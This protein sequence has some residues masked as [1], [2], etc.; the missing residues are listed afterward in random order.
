MRLNICGWLSVGLIYCSLVAH[1]QQKEWKESY[2]PDGKLRYKGY[3]IGKQPVG[4]VV[5]YYPSGQMKARLNYDGEETKA[6]IY[7]K[8]GE[9]TSSGKYLNREKTGVWEYRKG[10]RLLTREEYSK[11][12]LDG[13]SF[14]YYANGKIAEKK[15]WK[16]GVLSGE[17]QVFYDNG[18]LKFAT[19]FVAGKLQGPLTAYS[20]EGKKSV[21]GEYLNNVKEG[22]WR[23]YD[24]EGK[25]IRERAYK[26]G[27]S[28]R[29]QEDDLLENEQ[30][31]QLEDN[32][33][34]IVDPANFTDEPEVYLQIIDN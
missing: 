5:Q 27:I 25:V 10:E 18:Q 29:Q 28:E 34:K 12:K 9:F 31:R 20:Y 23:Y 8:N 21:E 30:I 6:V 7:S 15:T 13:T 11:D 1:A 16:A 3:F 22:V 14:K 17:W 32:V 26:N 2:Y 19:I 24:E 33:R 4:E